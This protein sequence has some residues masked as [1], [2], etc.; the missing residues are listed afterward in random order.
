M[1]PK[2]SAQKVVKNASS[3]VFGKFDG[4]EAKDAL[5]TRGSVRTPKLPFTKIIK[6]KLPL[7]IYH[8]TPTHAVARSA[9][10]DIYIYLYL[11]VSIYLWGPMG[12][13]GPG[14]H[15]PGT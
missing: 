4:G 10:A 8:L 11:Y 13:Q 14:T 5:W 12:S 7:T 2:D 6:K 1:M 15:G 9:V 3:G